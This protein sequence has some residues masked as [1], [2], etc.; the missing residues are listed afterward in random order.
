LKKFSFR[1]LTARYIDIKT[2][3]IKAKIAKNARYSIY[4]YFPR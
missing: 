4:E 3:S 1:F 2:T